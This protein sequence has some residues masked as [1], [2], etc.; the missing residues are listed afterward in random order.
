MAK[1][2]KLELTWI[3][4]DDEVRLEPRVLIED[5]EL[6]YGDTDTENMIIHGNNLLALKALEQDYAGKV[7]CIY[8]DPLYNTGARIN[9]D[10]D[11]VGYEDANGL[12]RQ[13]FPKGMSFVD[14]ARKEVI[15]AV[16]KLNSRPRKCLNYA[17]P[18]EVFKE[19]TG[20][21]AIILLKGIRL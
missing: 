16:H 5:P 8:I 15:D 7:K 3:G 13:Y 6:S 2:Q 19:L 1:K 21:D 11:E 4:K 12:L 14:I 20:I 17:T 9:S 18:Y 10:G